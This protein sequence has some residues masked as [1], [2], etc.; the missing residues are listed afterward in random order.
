MGLK[1]SKSDVKN[2]IEQSRQI[3][4][5]SDIELKIVKEAERKAN[6]NKRTANAIIKDLGGK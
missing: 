1:I 2:I 6:I 4:I 3:I 5:N